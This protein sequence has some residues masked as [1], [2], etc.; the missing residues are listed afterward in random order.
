MGDNPT[1]CRPSLSLRHGKNSQWPYTAHTY[2]PRHVVPADEAAL[3]S[4][5]SVA[6]AQGWATHNAKP[7]VGVPNIRAS[8]VAVGR[9]CVFL[10]G[11]A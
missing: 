4:R 1:H 7:E 6:S 3:A 10:V 8:P 2:L 11:E 9:A 5:L